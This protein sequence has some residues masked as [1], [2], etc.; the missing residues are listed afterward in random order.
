MKKIT[1]MMLLLTSFGFAHAGELED[2]Q[3]LWDDKQFYK[4]FQI[5]NEN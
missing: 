5:F 4:S 2:A 1:L 3:K